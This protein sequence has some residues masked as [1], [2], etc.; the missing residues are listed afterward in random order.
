MRE[1]QGHSKSWRPT[2]RSRDHIG[3][4]NGALHAEC[5]G[6]SKDVAETRISPSFSSSFSY[7][8]LSHFRLMPLFRHWASLLLR[9]V[10]PRLLRASQAPV[11]EVDRLLKHNQK[12]EEI[13]LSWGSSRFDISIKDGTRCGKATQKDLGQRSLY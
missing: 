1:R 10:P 11:P 2:D 7:R 4:G 5:P 6:P 12:H 9:P 3:G 13:F 8:A